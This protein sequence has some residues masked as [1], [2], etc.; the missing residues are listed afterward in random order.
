MYKQ[1]KM[2]LAIAF[3]CSVFAV[4]CSNTTDQISAEIPKVTS[5]ESSQETVQ[6]DEESV[7]ETFSSEEQAAIS[8]DW[9]E[10]IALYDAALQNYRYYLEYPHEADMEEPGMY[11]LGG[12]L[13][14]QSSDEPMPE[15]AG[16]WYFDLGGDGMPELMIGNAPYQAYDGG[17]YPTEVLAVWTITEGEPECVLQGWS[18]SSY[19]LLDDNIWLHQYAS[20]ASDSGFSLFT[21]EG[22]GASQ[23]HLDGSGYRFR[24]VYDSETGEYSL[25]CYREMYEDGERLEECDKSEADTFLQNLLADVINPEMTLFS[26]IELQK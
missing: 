12:Y 6:A 15:F 20:S 14:M 7:E 13:I 4:G 2:L 9:D 8:D 23:V 11:G 1:R 16:F 5:E 24:D 10:Y 18:R 22:I 3:V 25:K 21:F 17:T 26:E 19:R